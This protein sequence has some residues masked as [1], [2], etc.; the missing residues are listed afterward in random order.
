MIQQREWNEILLPADIQSS[1]Q[2]QRV[3][4]FI[5]NLHQIQFPLCPS[6]KMMPHACPRHLV[7]R[8]ASIPPYSSGHHHLHA[9]KSCYTM[10]SKKSSS[11]SPSHVATS[12]SRNH[13][14]THMFALFCSTL[15]FLCLLQTKFII[16]QAAITEQCLGC[17]CHVSMLSMQRCCCFMTANLTTPHLKHSITVILIILTFAACFCLNSTIILTHHLCTCR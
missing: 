8:L 2:Q 6:M 3:P 4:E 11:S 7:D 9:S 15:L 17:I 13:H 16:V 1:R 10:T 5:R 14:R 12:T